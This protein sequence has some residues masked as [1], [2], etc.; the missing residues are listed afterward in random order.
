MNIKFLK[1]VTGED[2]LSEVSFEEPV[3][4]LKNP[5]RIMPTRDGGI[6]MGPLNPFAKGEKIQISQKDV[7]FE[8]E[9]DD[10]I[11]NAYNA[12]F[13]SGIVTAPASALNIVGD[14]DK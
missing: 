3:Y 10:E 6:G 8:D 14:F 5:V 4:I 7:I 11:R 13:G 1:L 12:Q 2:V 9:P